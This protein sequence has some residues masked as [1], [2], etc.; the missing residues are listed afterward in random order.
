MARLTKTKLKI[1]KDNIFTQVHCGHSTRPAYGDH[2]EENDFSVTLWSGGEDGRV[3]LT[4]SEEEAIRVVVHWLSNPSLKR[5]VEEKLL[6]L[7]P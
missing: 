5:A 4:L 2:P 3:R 1:G 7:R 6:H